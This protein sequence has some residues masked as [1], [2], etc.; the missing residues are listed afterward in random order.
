M[1]TGTRFRLERATLAL[2]I[3]AGKLE[4]VTIP[5]GADLE[6]VSCPVDADNNQMVTLL[7]QGRTVSM[8]PIVVTGEQGVVK[9]R[10]A[11]ME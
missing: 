3:I 5:P 2:E 9:V 1:F 6:V 4:T 10:A 7:W 8:F 11:K